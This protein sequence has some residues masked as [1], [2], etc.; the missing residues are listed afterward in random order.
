MERELFQVR[1]RVFIVNAKESV[2]QNFEKVIA[3]QYG[4]QVVAGYK[5]VKR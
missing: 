4:K 5:V 2:L 1:D 3:W